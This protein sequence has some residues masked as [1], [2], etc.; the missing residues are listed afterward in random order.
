MLTVD[1]AQILSGIVKYKPTDIECFLAFK[2][3]SLIPY[4]FAP[5]LRLGVTEEW[6]SILIMVLGGFALCLGFFLLLKKVL[7]W[8]SISTFVLITILYFASKVYH[9]IISYPNYAFGSAHAAGQYGLAGGLIIAGLVASQKFGAAFKFILLL[10]PFHAT[11]AAFY[12]GALAFSGSVIYRKNLINI[13]KENIT[14]RSYWFFAA[15]CFLS[16]LGMTLLDPGKVTFDPQTLKQLLHR[17]LTEWDSH[18]QPLM[19]FKQNMTSL[20]LTGVF[21]VFCIF[22]RKKIFSDPNQDINMS[23]LYFLSAAI[24]GTGLALLSQFNYQLPSVLVMTIPG[25]FINYSTLILPLVCLYYSKKIYSKSLAPA[26]DRF[27]VIFL[28]VY[29]FIPIPALFMPYQ[30][31]LILYLLYIAFSLSGTQLGERLINSLS[32]IFPLAVTGILI[33]AVGISIPI[34]L[35][36]FMNN[37]VSISLIVFSIMIF[38][39]LVIGKKI[40]YYSNVFQ[41][42]L[43][44]LAIALWLNSAFSFTRYTY[45][46][47]NMHNDLFYKELSSRPGYIVVGPGVKNVQIRTRRPVLFQSVLMDQI[48]YVKESIFLYEPILKEIYGYS[49]YSSLKEEDRYRAGVPEGNRILW[50]NR[51]PEEWRDLGKK[52]EFH[53]VIVNK[54]WNLQLPVVLENHE[55]RVYSTN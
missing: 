13:V 23:L 46:M 29:C 11:W 16:F 55:Y 10:F 44:G 15:F 17:Y 1:N 28:M 42:M 43:I 50:Q 3:K 54:N 27:F 35:L 5:F 38:A 39:A 41:V 19:A 4:V 2:E 31:H 45:S 21:I 24:L 7:E 33:V 14:D 52:F 48:P 47:Q 18:R 6:L 37:G 22:Q 30:I 25:R 34:D 36:I 9:Y 12:L 32:K 49:F 51:K 53:D 20:V 26:L 8:K 40:D